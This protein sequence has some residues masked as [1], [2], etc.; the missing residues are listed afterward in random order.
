M[1]A[2]QISDRYIAMNEHGLSDGNA[3]RK[4]GSRRMLLR[5]QQTV[6]ERFVSFKDDLPG[7]TA[8]STDDRKTVNRISRPAN[9]VDLE[10]QI[11]LLHREH[12]TLK[13]SDFESEQKR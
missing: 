2:A 7:H 5:P 12:Q 13:K 10:R 1:N 11:S 6:S 9:I 3:L 8:N 4:D